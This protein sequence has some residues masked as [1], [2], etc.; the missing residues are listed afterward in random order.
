MSS[1]RLELGPRGSNQVFRSLSL[2][3][4]FRG[5]NQAFEARIRSLRLGSGLQGSKK[6]FRPNQVFEASIIPPRHVVAKEALSRCVPAGKGR[7]LA[8]VSVRVGL[9]ARGELERPQIVSSVRLFGWQ[10][11][12]KSLTLK[13]VKP[14][15]VQGFE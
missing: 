9:G 11:T 13:G 4:V 1:S 6:V 14:T 10:G 8:A 7:V 12:S 2:E 15:S 3:S 5:S